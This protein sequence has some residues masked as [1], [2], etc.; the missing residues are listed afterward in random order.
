MVWVPSKELPVPPHP[1]RA[2]AAITAKPRITVDLDI[3]FIDLM[4]LF[5]LRL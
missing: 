4:F 5:R 3:G 1:E 2:A